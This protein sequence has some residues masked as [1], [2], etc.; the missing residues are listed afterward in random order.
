[1]GTK[2]EH[3]SCE[4]CTMIQLGLEQGWTQR[5]IARCVQRAPS[6]ISRELNR[7]GWSNPATAPKK[8]GRPPVAGGYRAPLTQQCASMLARTA[9]YPSRLAQDGPLWTHVERLLRACHSPEQIA[10]ILQRMHPD[11]PKLQVSHETIY[12]PKEV[13]L[14]DTALYAIPRGTLRSE[15]I[16][17][18]R[19]A[20]KRRR[21]RARGEDCR[22]QIPEMTS[23]HL[24][25]PEISERVIPGHWEGNLIKGARNASSIGTLVERTTLFVTLVKMEDATAETAA[26]AFGA[27]LNRV[28]AQRR[29][30]LT[31]DQG[32]EMA[33]HAR[34][35]EITGVAVYFA[36]LHSPWQRGINENTN[37]LLRQ[38]FPKGSDLSGFSQTEL[39]AVAWQLNTRPRKS[40]NFHCPAELFIPESFDFFKHHHQL[41][42][43]RT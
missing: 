42:A 39:D 21:P 17:C 33:Q 37:G 36:D 2:Y 4:E 27:V 32:R 18:L 9:Q 40:L 25:P 12:A 43:L 14:G 19:Q 38:Y 16:A 20:R 1:M 13:P 10:G 35:S 11:Q 28:D 3:L 7:N 15:L 6:S 29:L 30:S 23:I 24:R 31:Y 41:V 8:R 22:G 5:A 34:L 26:T